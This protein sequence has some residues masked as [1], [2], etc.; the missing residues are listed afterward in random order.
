MLCWWSSGLE[1][2][3]VSHTISISVRLSWK[4]ASKWNPVDTF[5]NNE[6]HVDISLVFP[7]FQFLL[8]QVIADVLMTIAIFVWNARGMKMSCGIIVWQNPSNCLQYCDFLYFNP[9]V[10]QQI[11]F[12]RRFI[13]NRWPIYLGH[14]VCT[15]IWLNVLY[16]WHMIFGIRLFSNATLWHFIFLSQWI[17]YENMICMEN[18]FVAFHNFHFRIQMESIAWQFIGVYNCNEPWIDCSYQC[19][20]K[21]IVVNSI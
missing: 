13:I 10:Q 14:F 1:S 6:A 16:I 7:S 17:N 11:Y 18:Q 5:V 12:Q 9:P 3:I 21:K 2:G 20:Q 15:Y 8:M 19:T 4:D